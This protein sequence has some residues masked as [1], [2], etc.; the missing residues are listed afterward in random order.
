LGDQTRNFGCVTDPPF[1]FFDHNIPPPLAEGMKA[2]GERVIH[3]Q[4]LYPS[5]LDIKDTEWMAD[6]A[7]AGYTVLTRDLKMKRNKLELDEFRR[8][9]LG[10]FWLAGKNRSACEMIQQVVRCWPRMKE[11]ARNAGRPFIYIVPIGGTK[12]DRF[13]L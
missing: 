7:K 1:F 12:L 4:E 3:L 8:H 6:V 11:L 13:D 10:G 5:R 9:G 2:F